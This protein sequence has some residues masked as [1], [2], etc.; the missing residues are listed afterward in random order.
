[1]TLLNSYFNLGLTKIKGYLT[2]YKEFLSHYPEGICI[3]VSSDIIESIFGK[4]KVKANNFVLTGLTKLNLEL[5]LFCKTEK[6]IIQLTHLALEGI[7][8]THLGRWVIEYSA[9]NQLIRKMRFNKS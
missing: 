4:Y 8:M 2:Q 7:S 1:M 3:H 6:E 9:D 5:P